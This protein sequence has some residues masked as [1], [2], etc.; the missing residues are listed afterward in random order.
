LL[1][2]DTLYFFYDRFIGNIDQMDSD[3]KK[4]LTKIMNL[5]DNV[6]ISLIDKR[7]K[8]K[9]I[10]ESDNID[11]GA[12]GRFLE[13]FGILKEADGE[14]PY[15]YFDFMEDERLSTISSHLGKRNIYGKKE[16]TYPVGGIGYGH[17]ET[18]EITEKIGEEDKISIDEL[19]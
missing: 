6:S 17:Y 7:D 12:I 8:I 5:Y 16:V 9:Q 3:T 15:S 13:D 10:W 14:K 2:N 19:T 11:K 4:A 1:E 18:R